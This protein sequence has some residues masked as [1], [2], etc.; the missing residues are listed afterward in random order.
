MSRGALMLLEKGGPWAQLLCFGAFIW[1]A[2]LMLVMVLQRRHL[3]RQH[4]QLVGE[5]AGPG[6]PE[7]LTARVRAAMDPLSSGSIGLALVAIWWLVIIAA[8]IWSRT[9]IIDLS[10]MADD[11]YIASLTAETSIRDIVRGYSARLITLSMAGIV[12]VPGALV[13][14]LAIDQML[15]RP[16]T[17]WL[18]EVRR[19]ALVRDGAVDA[20][21]PRLR[22]LAARADARWNWTAMATSWLWLLG[23]GLVR[24]GLIALVLVTLG[25]AV[26]GVAAMGLGLDASVSE[27]MATGRDLTAFD[28]V[29]APVLYTVLIMVPGLAVRL[30]IAARCQRWSWRRRQARGTTG[31]A[32]PQAVASRYRLPVALAGV[33]LVGVLAL[34]VSWAREIPDPRPSVPMAAADSSAAELE[35]SKPELLQ[36]IAP[37]YPREARADSVSGRVVVK[38]LVLIDGTVGEASVL[39]GVDPRLDAAA[40]AAARQ[41]LWEPAR[42]R[43]I[44]VQAWMALPYNFE[45]K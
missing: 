23:H 1:L 25:T 39:E 38:V 27:R 24:P 17:R 42:Q 37:E 40:L 5:E 32:D 9:S 4:A 29:G 3:A 44:P 36:F 11:A 35:S 10:R 16:R 8:V 28:L 31:P 33:G 45:L 41:T 26:L 30:V 21:D 12:G 6:D 7:Q 19:R 22:A 15:I 18:D 2:T 14:V 43:G 34:S 20:D 13:S